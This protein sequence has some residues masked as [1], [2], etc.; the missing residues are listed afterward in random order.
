MTTPG[1]ATQWLAT[2]H[3]PPRSL[4]LHVQT[5]VHCRNRTAQ[6]VPFEQANHL[7]RDCPFYKQGKEDWW[8]MQ[9]GHTSTPNPNPSQN[10]IDPATAESNSTS[11]GN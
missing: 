1:A 5:Y 4:R 10:H 8:S 2:F 9:P 6:F 3:L 7:I 11:Q